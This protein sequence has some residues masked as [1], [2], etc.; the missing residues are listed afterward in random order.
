MCVVLNL[1]Y[2][3]R[4]VCIASVWLIY[5]NIL[6]WGQLELFFFQN[7]FSLKILLKRIVCVKI[8]KYLLYCINLEELTFTEYRLGNSEGPSYTWIHVVLVWIPLLSF[9]P[10]LSYDF[11]G[12]RK[13]FA[14][15]KRQKDIKNFTVFFVT[16]LSFVFRLFLNACKYVY[17]LFAIHCC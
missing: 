16:V 14:F 11:D 9:Q 8:W 6:S 7:L 17:R 4:M 2:A 15:K 13:F 12:D 1:D 5:Y 10:D 3:N